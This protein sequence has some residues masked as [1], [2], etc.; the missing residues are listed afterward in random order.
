MLTHIL[1][2][3]VG[4]GSL[5]I[6]LTAFFFPEVHRKNDFIWSG[7]GLFYA[8]IL[9]VFTPR[10][11]GWFFLGQLAAV[12]L[13]IWFGLQTFSL[14]RQV[15]PAMQQTPAPSIEAVKSNISLQERV[16]GLVRTLSNI[17]PGKK[18]QVS[19][20]QTTTSTTEDTNAATIGKSLVDAIDRD[21]ETKISV[22]DAS[23][24]IV[25]NT[26]KTA[27]SETI[28]ELIPPEPPAQELVEAAAQASDAEAKNIPPVEEIAPDAE[29][30]PPAEA[31]SDKIPPQDIPQG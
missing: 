16:G 18:Q 19:Q 1:A 2:L 24:V 5:A 21:T 15:T 20:T 12:A 7:V 13:L 6:Y 28:P 8:L 29:L 26:D 25:D 11:G 22:S 17:L 9:W 30:A 3:I 31:P 4:F 14:R 10:I 23:V 27:T